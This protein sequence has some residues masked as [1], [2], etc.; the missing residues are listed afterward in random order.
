MENAQQIRRMQLVY[1]S[2][3]EELRAFLGESLA[4]RSPDFLLDLALPLLTAESRLLDVGCRDGRHL[5]PLVARSGC[6][7][8]G[9]DPVER[10]LER[11]RAAVT[12][13][14]LDQ[15][16]DVRHGVME[17]IGEPDCSVDVVWCRDVIEVIT[18]LEAGLSEVARVLKRGGAAV[19]YTVFATSRLEPGEAAALHEPL[20][21]V[22]RN[23]DRA[24]V[25]GAFAE[26]GLRV[27]RLEE[28]GTEFREYDEER[29]QPVS[30]SLLR[31]ARLRRR[32]EDAI[33]RF[34]KDTSTCGKPRFTGSPTS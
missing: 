4:P 18:D 14:G 28:I 32:R 24:C 27:E 13:A 3:D 10:N 33:R 15:R 30:A 1:G 25:E 21:T 17:Q 29:T 8:T 31:L 2:D 6:T 22:P 5:I 26:A 19:V 9:I 11:A 16:I 12:A 7:G 34:G 23:L 20:A